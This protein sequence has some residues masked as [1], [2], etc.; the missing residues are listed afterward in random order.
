MG[1]LE[2]CVEELGS[3]PVDENGYIGVFILDCLLACRRSSMKQNRYQNE[4]RIRFP[5]HEVAEL[6]LI[7]DSRIPLIFQVD[8]KTIN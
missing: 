3:I 2:Q 1:I 4:V 6:L 5:L 7:P 8:F